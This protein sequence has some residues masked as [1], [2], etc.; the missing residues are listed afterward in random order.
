M[1]VTGSMKAAPGVTVDLTVTV[2]DADTDAESE[3]R[4]TCRDLQ[5]TDVAPERTCGPFDLTPERGH[6]YVVVLS[7]KYSGISEIP[8]GL[9]RGDVV[10]W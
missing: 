7:W 2:H 3:R 1:R 4:F 9:V 10:N 6:R 8:G 5:F